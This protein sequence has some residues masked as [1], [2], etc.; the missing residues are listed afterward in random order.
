MM[1]LAR[2][3][4][5]V[6]EIARTIDGGRP[7]VSRE[8][9][10]NPSAACAAPCCRASI[11]QHKHERR[12]GRCHGGRRS[13]RGSGATSTREALRRRDADMGAARTLLLRHRRGRVPPLREPLGR[14]GD[15]RR[16]LHAQEGQGRPQRPRPLGFHHQRAR[17]QRLRCEAGAKRARDRSPRGRFLEAVALLVHEE[18]RLQQIATLLLL[19]RRMT[20]GTALANEASARLR[21]LADDVRAVLSVTRPDSPWRR[22]CDSSPSWSTAGSDWV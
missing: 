22:P 10:R 6:G 4:K 11:A 12:R 14:R 7:A 15:A 17:N 21:P 2:Q 9:A 20:G 19:R 13:F 1:L 16:A 18:P 3:H 5:G 8:L